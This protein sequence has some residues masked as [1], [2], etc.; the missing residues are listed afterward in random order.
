MRPNLGSFLIAIAL[1]L[2]PVALQSTASSAA[3]DPMDSELSRQLR[4]L[5]FT[6]RVES[7]LTARLGRRVD[8]RLANLGRLLWFDT[9]TGLKGDNTCAGC[10]SPTNGF[11]DSQ[12]IAIGIDNNGIVGPHRAGPRN[13]RRA[14]M[15]L[16]T[17]FFP[18]LMWNGRF[19]SVSGDPFDNSAGFSFP[20]P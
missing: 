17:A 6:G 18:A 4:E 10:H 5:C 1:A 2:V 12:P 11:G 16:N 14:P 7:T 3:P 13:M 19:S 8:P 9:V 15:V 20:A